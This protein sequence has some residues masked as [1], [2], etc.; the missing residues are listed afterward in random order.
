MR[1]ISLLAPS[2]RGRASCAVLANPSINLSLSLPYTNQ[3]L[4]HKGCLIIHSQHTFNLSTSKH[5]CPSILF[6]P[7]RS[8]GTQPLQMAG[9]SKKTSPKSPKTTRQGKATVPETG[10]GD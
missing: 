9:S 4:H 1:L 8:E 2:F 10:S 7:L 6:R 3:I 5:H